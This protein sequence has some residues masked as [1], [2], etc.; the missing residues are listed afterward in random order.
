MMRDSGLVEIMSII[1][2]GIFFNI[3]F[4]R[5]LVILLAFQ[6]KDI[7]HQY[8]FFWDIIKYSQY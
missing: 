7:N 3:L 8:K 6:L 1:H 5:P 4:K 2:V